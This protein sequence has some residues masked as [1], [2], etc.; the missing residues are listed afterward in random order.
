MD[1]EAEAGIGAMR[2]AVTF[3]AGLTVLGAACSPLDKPARAPAQ[4]AASATPPV[5][6]AP[7]PQE[8]DQQAWQLA[9]Q[10]HEA[11]LRGDNLASQRFEQA[12][13]IWESLSGAK[14]TVVATFD[15]ASVR[16]SAEVKV[17][18]SP[19]AGH[20]VAQAW[21]ASIALLD[22]QRWSLIGLLEGHSAAVRSLAFSSD[23]AWLFSSSADRTVRRWNVPLAQA[24]GSTGPLAAASD[25]A[26][27]PDG[28]VAAY[29]CGAHLCFWPARDP[30]PAA[31]QIRP[32]EGCTAVRHWLQGDVIVT[33]NDGEDLC[34]L[35]ANT[36]AVRKTL[37]FMSGYLSFSAR[38]TTMVASVMEGESVRAEV[39]DL[40]EGKRL[41]TLSMER[42]DGKGRIIIQ[43]PP[44]VSP[45]GTSVAAATSS[46]EVMFW[47]A[48]TGAVDHAMTTRVPIG[49]PM[50][51]DDGVLALPHIRGRAF[52]V[53][54][55]PKLEPVEGFIM[56]ILAA[57]ELSS[58]PNHH[59]VMWRTAASMSA[60]STQTGEALAWPWAE[61]L[62][63]PS[64]VRCSASNTLVSVPSSSEVVVYD[65]ASG[66]LV[67]KESAG[68]EGV[69]TAA[70]LGGE[71]AS[72]VMTVSEVTGKRTK[73]GSM[74]EVIGLGNGSPAP[75]RRPIEAHLG[76]ELSADGKVLV[77]AVA[78]KGLRVY[79]LPGGNLK[80]TLAVAGPW[81]LSP[82]GALVAWGGRSGTEEQAETLQL[83][84][85]SSGGA[86]SLRGI[87]VPRGPLGW[88]GDG[89]AVVYSAARPEG[90][91]EVVAVEPGAG[92]ILWQSVL[93]GSAGLTD[94]VWSGAEDPV[95][96]RDKA[97]R[98]H[99]LSGA[100]GTF[101]FSWAVGADGRSW[102]ATDAAGRLETGGATGESLLAC[103]VGMRVLPFEVC[104]PRVARDGLVSSLLRQGRDGK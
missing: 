31:R 51:L 46:R 11:R 45:D 89:G 50:Y 103:K 90:G 21:G 52:D 35:D 16:P 48:G 37:P 69:V 97:G 2:R 8:L 20:V 33:G 36:G 10:G 28:M 14:A 85:T 75:V 71:P 29:Q 78:G 92:R 79:S 42:T 68:A 53:L 26:M 34:L 38:S 67:H 102:F 88:R 70:V 77:A 1:S 62:P 47:N 100:A 7:S 63:G 61:Q 98:I 94:L 95:L 15:E 99:V 24:A 65:T 91:A 23:G 18:A 93:P 57:P 9:A 80:R 3:M 101:L 76:A 41:R 74:A 13:A 43:G 72:L 56:P 6:P 17:I 4:A 73:D 27:S 104:R 84:D 44:S 82:N 19:R 22:S 32:S 12:L 39:W 25:V 87:P 54:A 66:H 60:W 5:P 81:A 86:R 59:W 30:A 83:A 49:N 40:A 96:A 58:A 64:G 55:A